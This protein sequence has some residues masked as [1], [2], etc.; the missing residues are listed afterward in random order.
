MTEAMEKLA[1]CDLSISVSDQ[2]RSDE[3]G[4]MAKAMLVFRQ[5]AIE[6]TRLEGEDAR[7]HQRGL[8]RTEGLEMMV[9]EFD[10]Q[11]TGI[12]S[13]LAS[14]A[15]ELEM[16][17]ETM[18]HSVR[19]T[20]EQ[21]VTVVSASDEASAN[22]ETVA[23]ASNQLSISI[24]EVNRQVTRSA[25]IARDAADAASRTDD[26][27][28]GLA[29][30]AREI[31]D[32]VKL[33]QEISG[34][35]NLLALNATIE[36]ARAGDAGKGFAV[37]ASEVKSLA[38]QTSNATED[39]AAQIAGIRQASDRAATAIREISGTVLEM[40]AIADAIAKTVDQQQMATQEIVRNVQHAAA[41]TQQVS[42]GIRTVS[43]AAEETGAAAGQ[44]LGAARELFQQSEIMR[45]LV[46]QFLGDVRAA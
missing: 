2:D 34:Q 42:R 25:S 31:G 38:T 40:D 7:Q 36:A 6:R 32:V 46:T 23:T 8:K 35:T 45:L 30:A 15:T 21:V 5:N 3:I 26:T 24:S 44:V 20:G 4:D 22:A 19:Q 13:T 9:S 11:I 12:L 18:S 41:A 14:A 27:V 1:A 17:A 10:R 43:A 33:I 28:L 16:T 39:I 29:N 37:V